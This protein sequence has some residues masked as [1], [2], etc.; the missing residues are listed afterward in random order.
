MPRSRVKKEPVSND[1]DNIMKMAE[2]L[3]QLADKVPNVFIMAPQAEATGIA[4]ENPTWV[5]EEDFAVARSGDRCPIWGDRLPYKSATVVVPA[6]L[7]NEAVFS[8]EYVHGTG[9]VSRHQLLP[10]GTM[11]LRSDYQCW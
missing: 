10:D 6:L 5:W 4:V 1:K 8:L 7:L 2:A 3:A 9:C 11:A